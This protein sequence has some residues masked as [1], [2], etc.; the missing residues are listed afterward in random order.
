M[1]V[2]VNITDKP[3]RVTTV[4]D[5]Q[6]LRLAKEVLEFD[7]LD[8]MLFVLSVEG[9]SPSLTLAIETGME[10][11]S[12]N[13]WLV[14]STPINFAFAAKT[15]ANTQ[16]IKN[17]KGF[18]RFVRWKVTAFAGTAITFTVTGVGRRWA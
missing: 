16:E 10:I 7:E 4:N 1:G 15:A 17:F 8:L 13:G 12:S 14:P 2:L 9:A 3:I 5:V 6:E 11:D 18:G